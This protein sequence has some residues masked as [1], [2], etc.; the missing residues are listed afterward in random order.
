MLILLCQLML[1]ASLRAEPVPAAGPAARGNAL[2]FSGDYAQALKAYADAVKKRST[3]VSA[4]LNGGQV[5]EETAPLSTL[6]PF[7]EGQ[8]FEKLQDDASAID[9][10]KK[11]VIEDSYFVEGREA[12]GRVELR[13][14]DYNAA[15]RQFSKVLD[16]EPH[17]KRVQLLVDRV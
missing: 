3:T 2:Y 1:A 14:R 7:Y 4:W 10:Y 8:A 16:A 6:V 12:L 13:R 9:A 17:S 15:W 11:A 5:L